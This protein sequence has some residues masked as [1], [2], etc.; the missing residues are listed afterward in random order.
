MGSPKDVTKMLMDWR[1]GDKTALDRL[2]PVVYDELRRIAGSYL[3]RERSNHTLQTTALVHEAYLRLVGEQDT[4]WQNRAHFFAVAA[5]MMR[6][7][8]VSYAVAQKAEKRGGNIYKFPLDEAIGM[9]E[10]RDMDVLAL[11]DAL[12]DLATMDPRKS[13]VVELRFFAGL[14]NE[15]I[16]EVMGISLATVN[17]EWRLIKAWLYNEV[18]KK[19]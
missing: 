11:N 12:N 8:L 13:R 6:N 14:S 19:A 18:I 15:E 9:P 1:E 4:Q 7:I 16:A 17:R 10:R 5:Q 2:L 3:R